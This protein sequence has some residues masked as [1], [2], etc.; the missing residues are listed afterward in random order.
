MPLLEVIPLEIHDDDPI[1]G[2]FDTIPACD[3]QTHRWIQCHS[4]YRAIRVRAVESRSRSIVK[5]YLSLFNSAP[6][7]AKGLEN[8]SAESKHNNFSKFAI[9]ISKFAIMQPKCPVNQKQ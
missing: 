3:R 2:H 9:I 7:G 6:E 4:I 8:D 5:H 1:F